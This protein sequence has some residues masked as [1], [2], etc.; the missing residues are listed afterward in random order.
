MQQIRKDFHHGDAENTE[1]EKLSTDEHRWTQI[2]H[3]LNICVHP[4]SSVDYF[5]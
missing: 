1:E 5:S 4:C 3:F 2:N